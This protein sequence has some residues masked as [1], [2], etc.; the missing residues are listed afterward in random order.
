MSGHSVAKCYKIHGYPPGH[1]LHGK[2]KT[3]TIAAAA[4]VAPSQAC[5]TND[6]DEESSET[7]AL[8]KGQ[9]NQLL[10]L[11]HSKDLSSAMATMFVT[12]PFPPVLPIPTSKL[13]GFF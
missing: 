4:A 2:N 1:K 7:M 12:P 6:H 3:F 13:S 5:S 8:T 11:L 10:A 9:Y